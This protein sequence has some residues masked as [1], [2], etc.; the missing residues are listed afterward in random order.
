M[1]RDDVEPRTRRNDAGWA[2]RV[3]E[4][5]IASRSAP[6]VRSSISTSQGHRKPPPVQLV[7]DLQLMDVD[8]LMVHRASRNQHRPVPVLQCRKGCPG[9][10][11]AD[12]DVG[13][14]DGQGQLVGGHLA[15]PVD[16][17]VA[18][19]RRPGPS[20]KLGAPPE[21]D[22]LTAGAAGLAVRH[23]WSRRINADRDAD[24]RPDP[25][26]DTHSGAHVHA[27]V[28]HHQSRFRLLARTFPAHPA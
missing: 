5:D 19:V 4:T 12:D 8:V 1:T 3:T 9:A 17:Q 2:E 18:D 21:G 25:R 24:A 26:A 13:L 20:V 11:V 28:G 15:L 16:L 27:D 22:F 23:T 7:R 14:G 6:S 10:H